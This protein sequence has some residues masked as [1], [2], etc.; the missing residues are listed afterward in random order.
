MPGPFGT[1]LATGFGQGIIDSIFGKNADQDSRSSFD[2]NATTAL[3][4][5]LL[6]NAQRT[7]IADTDFAAEGSVR[8]G[9]EASNKQLTNIIG[10]IPK[11]LEQYSKDAAIKDSKGAVSSTISELLNANI[12]DIN[13][14]NTIAG[15][16]SS[17][18]TKL[19]KD[20]IF[21][22][23]A[24][25]GAK[26]QQ[27]AITNYADIQRQGVD[28]L[29]G[30]LGLLQD[31]NVDTAGTEATSELEDEDIKENTTTKSQGTQ[32]TYGSSV[33]DVGVDY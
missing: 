19:L 11:V 6:T 29:L 33:T 25:A 2:Q 28:T 14:S 8:K 20:N 5:N 24:A 26:V 31:S 10:R 32:Q 4:E 30:A 9:T 23:A 18:T 7:R 16:Y 15:G 21:A 13:T 3:L 22:Q 12:P 17:T 1:A 27:E